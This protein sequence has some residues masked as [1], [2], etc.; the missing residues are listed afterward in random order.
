MGFL[1]QVRIRRCLSTL[2]LF[3]LLNNRPVTQIKYKPSMLVCNLR[4]GVYVEEVPSAA[5]QYGFPVVP[6]T[7]NHPEI[8]PI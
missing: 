5:R 4:E 1:I 8:E 7:R 2:R 3:P 6:Y